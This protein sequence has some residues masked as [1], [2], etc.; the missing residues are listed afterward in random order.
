MVK[1][2]SFS[3]LLILTLSFSA[4]SQSVNKGSDSEIRSV[5]S[6]EKTVWDKNAPLIVKFSIENLS[7]SA[8][9][10]SSSINFTL[11]DKTADSRIGRDGVSAPVS[12][13]KTYDEKVNDCQN[14]LTKERFTKNGGILPVARDF[15][16]AKGEKKEFSFDLSKICWN[17]LISSVYPNQNLF[18]VIKSGKYKISFGKSNEIEIEIIK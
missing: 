7:E 14:D 8:I 17:R 3:V 6:T 18:T 16:L 1:L 13:T 9:N 12:L 11:A 5:L 4:L 10:I 15:F 2:F